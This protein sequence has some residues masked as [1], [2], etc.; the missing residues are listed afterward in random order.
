M[1]LQL[2]LVFIAI[3]LALIIVGLTKPNESA[4]AL[5]GF[6]FLFL[7]SFVILGNNLE[8]KT[9]ETINI[10]NTFTDGNLTNSFENKTYSYNTWNDTTGAF[11]THRFG[12]FLAIASAVG[13]VGTLMS[14]KGSYRRED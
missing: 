1:I 9:G 8:Y 2:F 12:Y 3:S 6:F 13:F 14:V 4:Q 5:I 7:L 11:N 10:T